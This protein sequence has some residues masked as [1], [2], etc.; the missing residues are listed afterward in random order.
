MQSF[1]KHAD[2]VSPIRV[3]DTINFNYSPQKTS[4]ASGVENS[5]VTAT[6]DDSTLADV[7]PNTGVGNQSGSIVHM[8]KAGTVTI[9]VAS[10]NENNVPY[11]DAYQIVIADVPQDLTDHFQV[12]EV[13]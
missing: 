1:T 4:G 2:G 8:L 9:T 11:H 13:N 6:A 3:G 7:Q 10:T 5:P 12:I